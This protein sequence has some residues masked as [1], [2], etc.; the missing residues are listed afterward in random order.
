VWKAIDENTIVAYEMNGAPLPH[1]NASLPVSS[2]P[3]GRHVL[4]EARH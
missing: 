4:D 1:F 3:A 2:F